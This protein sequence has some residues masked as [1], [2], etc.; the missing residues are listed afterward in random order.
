AQCAGDQSLRAEVEGLLLHHRQLGDFLASAPADRG[1]TQDH[2]PIVERPGAVIG[3]Y[4]L[5]EQIGE[6]GMG[7]VFMA[8]Q[9]RPVQRRVA[10]KI[11]KPGMDTKQV[12]ARFEAERQALALMDHPNIA[13]VLD[14]GATETGRPYFVMELVRGVPLT[15]FCD[16]NRLSI[17]QRLELFVDV[18]RAVQHA[19][20]KGIIHRD[21]K[22]TNVLVTLHDGQPVVKVIDFGVA[23]ATGQKLTEKTLFTGF[24]EMIGTPLYMS[25]EQAELSGLDIDTRSDIY[26]L[27][28]LLY[29]LLTGHTPFDS[30][31]LKSA[32]FD[33]FR[34]IIREE[35]PPRPSTRFSSLSLRG[36]AGVRV[37]KPPGTGSF[38]RSPRS[39]NVPVPL[40]AA[41]PRSN[42]LSLGERAGVRGS[43]NAVV[44]ETANLAST[45]AELRG[46]D[47]RQL[48]KLFQGELDW[49][50]MK[51]LEKDRNRRYET[52]SAFS[53]DVERYLADEPVQACPPS[54]VYRFRK[55]IRR[56]RAAILASALLALMLLIV[57][58]VI[59]GSIGWV[60]RDRASRAAVLKRQIDEAIKE[61]QISYQSG[62]LT[63]A[64]SA[65]KRADALVIDEVGSA[66]LKQQVD[67]WQADLQTVNRLEQIRLDQASQPKTTTNEKLAR[68]GD[69]SE[70]DAD[71]EF[72]LQARGLDQAAANNAYQS[73]FRRFGLELDSID[74]EKAAQRISTSPI[75]Q[76]L[77]AALD[78][79]FHVTQLD[80]SL[81]KKISPG[82]K[83]LLQI[84]QRADPDSLRDRLRD[85]IQQGDDA[86]I[87]Q[88]AAE[89]SIIDQP[90]PTVLLLV[91]ALQSR[92]PKSVTAEGEAILRQVQRK[93]PADFWVNVE[94]AN[95]LPADKLAE[96]IG[97]RRIAVSLRPDSTSA[98]LELAE[99]LSE[100][101]DN[102]EVEATYREIVRQ[103]PNDAVAYLELGQFL[104]KHGNPTEAETAYR[105]AVRLDPEK[106]FPHEGLGHVLVSQHRP[107]EAEAEFREA[108]RLQP[109]SWG[110]YN[111]L[112]H[113]L[114]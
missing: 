75:K 80:N 52:A 29:E 7:V 62:K 30:Q 3:P 25:P 110:A 93:H 8:E 104:R 47:P 81:S 111:G 64:I 26:S 98:Q 34:R 60:A 11:I 39:K 97:F 2:A 96:E 22:P 101:G 41:G 49:I 23:K 50:V 103:A 106:Y 32:A 84:A 65:V 94:M 72:R 53:A 77:V 55:T 16:Q 5:L 54:A 14:A 100:Q 56:H 19:H 21:L 69:F 73:E 13:R 89:K 95:C 102:A 58:G 99:H 40:S 44:Q 18:C 15:E 45:I 38:L 70:F 9:T 57:V 87:T 109:D 59:A 107:V 91:R 67:Q 114:G 42:S 36:R 92:D 79:W 66:E 27:G 35:E 43:E 105:E 28:V 90:I 83:S 24:A 17:R 37:P 85:A 33:E 71:D 76:S 20:Q 46:S 88:L 63:E 86:A 78:D 4:K 112:G 1:P 74:V 61:S 12:V 10:L 113:A 51:A 82:D 48:S 108:I 6:G 31:R 68:S